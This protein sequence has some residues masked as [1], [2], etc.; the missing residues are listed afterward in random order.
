MHAIPP[1]QGGRYGFSGP[2]RKAPSSARSGGWSLVATALRRHL[3]PEHGFS[4]SRRVEVAVACSAACNA[5][6]ASGTLLCSGLFS[7]PIPCCVRH[8]A[9]LTATGGAMRDAKRWDPGSERGAD[10]Q[11]GTRARARRTREVGGA[12][13]GVRKMGKQRWSM[14][15]LVGWVVYAASFLLPV[16]PGQ[17]NTALGPE[18]TTLWGWQAFLGALLM[19]GA[20][21]AWLMKFSAVSNVLVLAT[22]LKLRG[23]RPPRSIWLPCGLTVAALL[24]LYWGFV[25]I[26]Q[27]GYWAW[28]ASFA[29][30]AAAL[31]IRRAAR[32]ASPT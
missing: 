4:P 19:V 9:C 11:A 31:W 18:A 5:A 30:I 29:C 25:G 6:T 2:C 24:N 22:F 3:L 15:L 7:H 27:V 20:S 28:V 26:V 12:F 8:I 10:T 23:K 32:P 16:T 1:S 17:F 14:L 21:P 13:S